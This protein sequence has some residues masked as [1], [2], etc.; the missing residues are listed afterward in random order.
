[1][2]L[3]GSTGKISWGNCSGKFQ[4]NLW[5]CGNWKPKRRHFSHQCTD[6][7]TNR[8]K[9][10]WKRIASSCR[11]SQ[12]DLICSCCLQLIDNGWLRTNTIKLSW[13]CRDTIKTTTVPEGIHPP[14]SAWSWFTQRWFAWP[15]F[16]APQLFFGPFSQYFENNRHSL[17][18][19]SSYRYLRPNPKMQHQVI[20]FRINWC[21]N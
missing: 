20:F 1:M 14:F 13:P 6:V 3:R 12:T 2:P 21:S 10:L 15:V 16:S 5:F 19:G 8:W 11:E 4:G 17:T 18:T 9:E 7:V